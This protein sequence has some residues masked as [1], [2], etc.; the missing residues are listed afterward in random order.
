[1]GMYIRASPSE[2]TLQNFP[3]PGIG[4][5]DRLAYALL[6]RSS[7]VQSTTFFSCSR[8]TKIRIVVGCNLTQAGTQPLNMNIGPSL[9]NEFL[10]T[11]SVDCVTDH[12]TWGRGFNA[13]EIRTRDPDPD[14]FMIRLWI[15]C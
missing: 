6:A 2:A 12:S 3:F 1:M 9:R 14:A 5:S 7:L 13:R 4:V 15:R 8:V 10:I 11:C